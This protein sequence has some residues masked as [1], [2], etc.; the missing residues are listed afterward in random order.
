M[1]KQVAFSSK[2]DFQCQLLKIELQKLFSSNPQSPQIQVDWTALGD[3]HLELIITYPL[4]EPSDQFEMFR[5]LNHFSQQFELIQYRLLPLY[6]KAKIE[7]NHF[8]LAEEN[9]EISFTVNDY[10]KFHLLQVAYPVHLK[11]LTYNVPTS[12][13]KM[14]HHLDAIMGKSQIPML[15]KI[16]QGRAAWSRIRLKEVIYGNEY[17]RIGKTM[18][19]PTLI[20]LVLLK[21]GMREG[22]DIIGRLAGRLESY[23]EGNDGVLDS[24][25]VF[26]TGSLSIMEVRVVV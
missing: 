3:D 18:D 10:N 25:L 2:L 13:L 26:F 12:A 17:F 7:L 20:R 14:T 24:S 22:G 16:P 23:L 8:E 11:S 15:Y 9:L 6:F 1:H 19:S 4:A 5:S 21:R